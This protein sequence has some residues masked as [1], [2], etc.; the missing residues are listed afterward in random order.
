[1][2]KR[3]IPTEADISDC[4][5]PTIDALLLLGFTINPPGAQN[6][7]DF[8]SDAEVKS[9]IWLLC[10][11]SAADPNPNHRYSAHVQA[12]RVLHALPA[13]ALRLE[14][15]H[16]M[17]FDASLPNL[18]ATAVGWLKDEILAAS[19]TE[20]I[21]SVRSEGEREDSRKFF[22]SP[23][24][25][26]R[27]RPD[28]F[29]E[30]P[31]DYVIEHESDVLAV[32]L[33]AVTLHLTVLNLYYMLITSP[34]LREALDIVRFHER[35][36]I[37]ERYMQ[38]LKTAASTA[39]KMLDEMGDVEIHDKMELTLLNDTVDMVEHAL[40]KLSGGPAREIV[41]NAV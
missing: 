41:A 17:L 11:L 15:T 6:C 10:N 3:F 30:I 1:M 31:T 2:L 16:N 28:L 21:A 9:Y 32:F 20:A 37:K 35:K 7:G 25:L 33:S 22:L 4:A 27:L 18:K 40:E 36:G 23:S 13:A 5:A 24:L 26:D 34:H 8:P 29:P 19:D 12:A 14:L 39:E 38:K